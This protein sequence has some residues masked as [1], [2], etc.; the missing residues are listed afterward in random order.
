MSTP[1]TPKA[2]AGRQ[3]I[4]NQLAW[5]RLLSVVEEQAQVLIHTAFGTSTR[6]AGDLS[7]GVFLPDG[8]MI[9]QAVT[10]TPGA[11]TYSPKAPHPYMQKTR[12]L[13][14]AMLI[15]GSV[16]LILYLE[17]LPLNPGNTVV[18]RGSNRAWSNRS[19]RR[20]LAAFSS[21]DGYWEG[22]R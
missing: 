10:G 13:D 20:A 5:N 18:M 16:T 4:R 22:D 11:S 8:R 7:A 14:F 2:L 19:N 21:H 12:T 3:L 15:E 1:P 17:E 6:E 9:A